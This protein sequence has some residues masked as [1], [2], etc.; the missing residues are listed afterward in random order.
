M[1]NI[2]IHCSGGGYKIESIKCTRLGQCLPPVLLELYT[3]TRQDD[4]RM[5]DWPQF[6]LLN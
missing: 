6:K 4:P 2:H 3:G 1:H 5:N